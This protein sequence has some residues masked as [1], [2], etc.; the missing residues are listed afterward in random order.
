MKKIIIL[1][2]IL[3]F[4]F[5]QLIIID[6]VN[7]LAV[8]QN[9][10]VPFPESYPK[11]YLNTPYLQNTAVQEIQEALQNLGY[12]NG[13]LSGKY[14]EETAKAVRLFQK[15]VGIKVDGITHLNVWL[16][17]ARET[18]KTYSRRKIKPPDGD[19]SLIIDTFKRRLTV[20]SDNE[21]YATFPVA[22][23]K[24]STPSPIGCW[25]IVSKAKN[26]GTGFGT[27]WM[28]LNVPWGI[29][30]IHGTNKP[31]SIGTMASHGCF[32]MLNSDVETIY[33]WIRHATPVYVVGNPFGY[34]SGGLKRLRRGTNCSQS[35]YVQEILKRRGFYKGNA[36]GLYG[37]GTVT[38]V[39]AFQKHQGLPITGEVGY[40]EYK[41]LGI[42]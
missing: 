12:Y 4:V 23:G 7:T 27:R 20:Y 16:K 32:R 6:N 21:P 3:F 2:S 37:Y 22:I 24:T 36:D 15:D 39:K 18:E 1:F 5:A 9:M 13:F 29:Y 31:W 34:M 42:K 33:G 14:D 38:A 40:E 8:D 17:L 11:L 41:A 26:W 30:G 35:F 28:G 10:Q 25:K 19:I